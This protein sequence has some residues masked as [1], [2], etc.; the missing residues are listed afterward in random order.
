M[1]V[2]QDIFESHA[3]LKHLEFNPLIFVNSTNEAD[4]EIQALRQRLMDRAK[5]HPRW[6]EHMPTAWVPLE[7]HLAQQAEKGITILT[8]DQIK[9][10]N[11]QNESMVLTEKQLETFLKVQHSLGKLLYFDL[12]NLRDSVII[13]PAYLVDV[14]RSIITE[15]QFW[16][17]GKRLRNIF[18]TMQRK[19]AVSRADMYDLWKQPIF[20]HILSYKDFIIEVL[21]HLD[22]LVAE[23]NNTE[24]LGTPIRDV[25]QFLVPSMITRPDDTKYMKKCYKSGTSILL[26]YKFIEKVIPQPFHTDLLLLL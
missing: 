23:R 1:K 25:T 18:H 6:G 11:S 8:K 2:I 4:P 16:P 14:L 26:S 5:E 12:A 10:F 22:I 9:M 19:G 21:V 3:G 7:L 20:E 13:T 17:K 24:D 15:K